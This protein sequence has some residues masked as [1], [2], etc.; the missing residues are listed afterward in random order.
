V[1]F[2]VKAKDGREDTFE[3]AGKQAALW[4]AAAKWGV[5]HGDVTAK[6]VRRAS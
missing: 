4:A 6:R 3:A 2:I 1:T 5:P